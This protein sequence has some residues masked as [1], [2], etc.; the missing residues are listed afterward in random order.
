MKV[1]V[2]DTGAGMTEEFVANQAVFRP[3]NTT[4]QNG[5]GIGTYESFQYI[6]ELGGQHH[7]DSK[8]GWGR[9]PWSPCCCRLFDLPAWLRPPDALGHAS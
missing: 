7:V 8:P 5:M 9:A 6:R 2:G 3:F 1:E 4:K